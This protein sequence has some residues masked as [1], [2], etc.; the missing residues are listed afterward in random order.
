MRKNVD[1]RGSGL[2]LKKNVFEP[3]GGDFK[4]FGKWD[5]QP[6]YG[7]VQID[8]QFTVQVTLH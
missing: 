4:P 1:V 6:I 2:K 8:A 7:F 5:R 3:F